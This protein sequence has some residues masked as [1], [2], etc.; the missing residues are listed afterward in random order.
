MTLKNCETFKDGDQD[1][2]ARN[3]MKNRSD[4]IDYEER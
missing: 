4:Y 1:P 3:V 2:S